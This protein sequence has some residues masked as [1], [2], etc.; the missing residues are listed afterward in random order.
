MKLDKPKIIVSSYDD[1]KNPFYGGGG[2]IAVHEVFKRLTDCFAVTIITGTY[3][4][5]KNETLENLVYKRIGSNW[6]GPKAG[7]IIFQ[8]LLPFYVITQKFD[9]WVESFTPPF[10]TSF[11]QLFTRKSVVGLVHMLSGQDMWKKYRLPFYLLEKLGLKTYKYFVVMSKFSQ[12]Q[13]SKV[14][15]KAK[16]LI[17]PN[18]VNKITKIPDYQKR[19]K[20]YILF[21]GRIEVNQKGL[22]LLIQALG[23]TE[24]L[25]YMVKI[26]GGGQKAE[27]KKLNSL[28]SA[29]NLGDK[30]ELTGKVGNETKKDLFERALFYVIPSRFETFSISALEALSFGIPLLTFDIEGLRWIPKDCA[31]KVPPQNIN[32]LTLGIKK[33]M[34][35][36]NLR[37]K[38]SQ[39][40]LVFTKKYSW[41]DTS[42]KYKNFLLQILQKQV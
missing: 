19:D 29:Y 33:L 36:G 14:N 42:S 32:K 17:A 40:S 7:Q 22:D 26:A 39:N 4:N 27:I 18:G 23:K 16:Y 1:L 3:P 24:D 21:I 13:I 37:N 34:H 41:E 6:F 11:L 35:D 9:L 31:M 30:I 12:I 5:S 38:L 15:S 20:K 25:I 2:A 8:L 28:I 10:S